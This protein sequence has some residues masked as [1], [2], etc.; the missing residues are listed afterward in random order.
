MPTENSINIATADLTTLKAAFEKALDERKGI[1]GQIEEIRKAIG[2][3]LKEAQ[4]LNDAANNASLGLSV[5]SCVPD[6][7]SN[8][9]SFELNL[10]A[11]WQ[12]FMK[13]ILPAVIMF[14]I[15]WFLM[16]AAKRIK[17]GETVLGPL[18]V[19]TAITASESITPFPLS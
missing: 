12:G 2:A 3:R 7:P 8:S 10:S 19:A 9:K 13:Y 17:S 16:S 14:V 11:L 6:G 5:T 15:L 18:N 4:T 1:D